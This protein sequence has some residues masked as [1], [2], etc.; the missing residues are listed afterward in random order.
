MIDPVARL[1]QAEIDATVARERLSSTLAILQVRLD[2]KRLAREAVREVKEKGGVA[3]AV[4]VENAR[5]NP[6][7]LAGVTAVAGLFLTRHKLASLVRAIRGK[8]APQQP[9]LD[10]IA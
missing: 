2:P 10:L 8:P 3:A 9:P 5:R 4:G 7:A 6:G 1:A